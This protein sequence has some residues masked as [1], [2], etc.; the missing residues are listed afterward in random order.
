MKNVGSRAILPIVLLTTLSV[1]GLKVNRGAQ[2]PSQTKPQAYPQ[3]DAPSA[4]QNAAPSTSQKEY[5]EQVSKTYNYRFGKD[6]I[7]LPGNAAIEG[8]GFLRA[9]AFPDAEYC[10]HCHEEAY[11]QWRES[12]HSNA[13]RTPFY[14]TSVNILIRD[15]GIEFARHCDSCHNPIGVLS[16]AL[17]PNAKGDRSFDRDGL[18][19]MVCH[20]IQQVDTKLGNGSF[21]LAVPAVIVDAQG[22]RIPGPVP[23]SEIL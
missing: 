10:G 6:N 21:T 11:R 2:D 20:S 23:D 16:G 18:T 7:S 17:D 3:T 14:R 4:A 13:F 19:C 1:F 8:G 22:N 15:K 9:G 5:S 12:L